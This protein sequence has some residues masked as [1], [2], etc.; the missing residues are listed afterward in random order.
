[1]MKSGSIKK[2]FIITAWS[3][4]ESENAADRLSYVAKTFAE[5]NYK[6]TLI[7]SDFDHHSRS[8]REE[9]KI[10]NTTYDTKLIHEIGYENN[11][12]FKRIFSHII[13]AKN[14]KK[15]LN[16]IPNNQ[17][18][19]LIYVTMPFSLTTLACKGYCRKH[20]IPLIVDVIDLWPEAF[21]GITKIPKVLSKLMVLPWQILS[22]RAYKVADAIVSHNYTYLNRALKTI[23]KKIPSEMVY[24]GTDVEFVNKSKIKYGNNIIKE[25]DEFWVAYVGGLAENYDLDTMIYSVDKLKKKGIHNIKLMF[26][27]TG[28]YETKLR[29]LAE[30]LNVNYYITGRIEYSKLIAYLCKCDIAVNAIKN[31]IIVISYKTNDYFSAGLPIINSSTGELEQLLE[32]HN[33]GLYYETGNVDMLSQAIE[34]LYLDKDLLLLMKS[35]SRQFAIKYLDKKSNY[36]RI[37]KLADSLIK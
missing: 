35:N 22:N 27:G 2:I 16:L 12:S 6:T 29:N 31:S 17:V 20:K 30:S 25:D 33:A 9:N 23:N 34:K 11:I 1:M 4:V 19:D 32:K 8:F 10:F 28:T 3:D 5:A 7:T 14:I 21:I 26:L 24:L 13:F 36:P 18:P 15:F 37:V